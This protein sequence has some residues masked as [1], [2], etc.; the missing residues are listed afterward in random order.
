MNNEVTFKGKPAYRIVAEEI[1]RTEKGI[2]M[3]CEGDNKWFPLSWVKIEAEQKTMIVPEWLYKQNFK[4]EVN[5]PVNKAVIDDRNTN[6]NEEENDPGE[7][8]F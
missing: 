3:N 1:K 7:A 2:L 8:P 5:E 4:N 6:D